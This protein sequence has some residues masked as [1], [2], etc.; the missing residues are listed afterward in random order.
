MSYDISIGDHSFNYT[1]NMAPLFRDHIEDS[2]AGGGIKELDGKTGAE[3]APVL[4]KA[5]RALERTIRRLHDDETKPTWKDEKGQRKAARSGDKA[6]RAKYDA[7]NGW[8]TTLSAVIF[9]GEL[10]AA[11]VECPDDVVSVS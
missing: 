5:F 6:M 11:C 9:L 8:G 1:W 7:E 2:G 10:M 4:G 3:A